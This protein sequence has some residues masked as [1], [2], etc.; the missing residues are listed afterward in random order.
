M[1]PKGISYHIKSNGLPRTHSAFQPL[2]R[3]E[4]EADKEIS[5][6]QTMTVLVFLQYLL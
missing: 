1:I 4:R 5:M 3:K 2:F 6:I